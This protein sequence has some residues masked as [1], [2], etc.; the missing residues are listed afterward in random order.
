MHTLK[1]ELLRMALYAV[2]AL[3][4]VPTVTLL[5]SGHVLKTWDRQFIEAIDGDLRKSGESAAEREQVLARF[6]ANPPSTVCG[7]NDPALADYRARACDPW[8]DQWQF[9]WAHTISKAMLFWGAAVAA[10]IAALCVAAQRD[11]DAQYRSLLI[12]WRLLS[13][14]GAVEVVVQNAMLAWLSFWLTAWYLERYSVKLVMLTGIGAA[15]AAVV[16]VAQIFARTKW[17]FEVEGELVREQD[18]PALWQRVRNLAQTLGTEPPRQIIGGIDTNFFVTESPITLAK[19]TVDGRSLFVSLP[20]LRVLDQRE[21]DAVLAH[22]LAHFSGGDTERSAKLGPALSQFDG[23]IGA[24]RGKVMTLVAFYP[25]IVYRTALELGLMRESRAREFLADRAAAQAVSGR[26]LISAL[27][28]ISAYGNYRGQIEEELF[29]R[30]ERHEGEIGISAYVAQGLKPFA[31]SDKFQ[32]AMDGANIPHPFDSHPKLTERMENVS[33][34]I[35]AKLFG[36]VVATEVTASWYSEILNAADI[37]SRLW[38]AYE[39]RF[40][41][42]HEHVL[43]YRYL[44]SNEQELAIVLK[45]FPPQDFGAVAVAY[46]GVTVAKDQSNYGWDQIKGINYEDGYGGDVLKLTVKDPGSGKTSTK[47]V[48]LPGIKPH[49]ELLKQTLGGYRHRHQVSRQQS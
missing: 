37:E 26:P 10:V 3:A 44:P 9:Y 45:Y 32:D 7:N 2:L 27:I 14:S 40:A 38:S 33:S 20:L 12:G 18:A 16:A 25:L 35:P 39:S 4:L 43:A 24:M 34:P 1:S 29:Q 42:A 21:A 17:K 41:Q 6:R 47:K 28:K 48:K 13:W 19:G 22:E 8:G 23:Y 49:R 15:A 46:D 5:F 36:A 31:Y 30:G 11:R